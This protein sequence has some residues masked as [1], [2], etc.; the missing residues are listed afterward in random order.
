MNVVVN[1]RWASDVVVTVTDDILKTQVLEADEQSK[2]RGHSA[3]F[4]AVKS[5]DALIGNRALSCQ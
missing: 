4:Q 5:R 3:Q 1:G 2:P